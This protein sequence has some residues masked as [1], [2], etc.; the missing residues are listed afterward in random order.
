M[1]DTPDPATAGGLYTYAVGIDNTDAGDATN[2]VL[3]LNVP[4]GATF[5]SASPAN[6]NCVATSATLVTCSIGTL[7]SNPSSDPALRRTI[8]LTWRALVAGGGGAVIA[9]T[10]TV[11]SDNDTNLTN[12]TQSVNTTVN[13]GADLRLTKTDAPDPVI[14]G[15]NIT[16]TLTAFNDGPNAAGNL[17]LSDSL[18]GS[19]T[20]I[21]ASGDGWSCSHT[22]GV[23]TCTRNGPLAV[24]A[25]APPVTVVATVNASGGNITNS[26]SI[27]PAVGVTPDPNTDNNTATISTSD[28]DPNPTNN[29]ASITYNTLPDGADLRIAKSKSPNPV[30]QG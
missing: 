7:V 29:S 2:T 28:N 15:A 14:G 18:P 6:A 16:Y 24:G 23:V 9:G 27:N 19:S 20:F 10:A 11:T 5:V 25:S 30:A 21:S 3:T 1:T 17:V 22:A 26:A 4:S 8:N 12:N 13:S